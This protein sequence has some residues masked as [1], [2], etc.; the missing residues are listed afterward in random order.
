VT[1]VHRRHFGLLIIFMVAA[2]LSTS[3]SK[4][5]F[6]P[7]PR[8]PRRVPIEPVFVTVK[9]D[10]SLALG[11]DPVSRETL[12][13][14]LDAATRNDKE[15]RI[16]VRGRPQGGLWR[17]DGNDEPAARRRLSQDRACR[18][19]GDGPHGRRRAAKPLETKPLEPKP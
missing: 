8:N 17:C 1:A 3:M 11:D 14:A 13:A 19:G 18:H 10:L 16:F 12:A 6:R 9:A 2:P 5:I 15:Q 7:P 4:S